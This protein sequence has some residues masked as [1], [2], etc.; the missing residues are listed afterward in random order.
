[1]AQVSGRSGRKNKRGKVVIQTIQPDHRVIQN[2]VNN[3]Y[4]AMYESEMQERKKFNYPPFF[5]LIEITL[6]HRDENLVAK[7]ARMFAS[8]LREKLK[9][10]VLGPEPPVVARVKSEW[11]QN[12]LVKVDRNTSVASAKEFIT[13]TK[14][15]F[16]ARQEFHRI[17]MDV[18]VDP[19]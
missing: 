1:M 2:V 4:E 16:F 10:G 14:N 3:N 12:I 17:G 6:R 15:T 11:R 13:N 18:D 9:S 5:R 8:M 7:G 19:M